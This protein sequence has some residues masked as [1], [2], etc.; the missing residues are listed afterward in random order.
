MP[1]AAAAMIFKDGAEAF[2]DNASA[3]GRWLKKHE[4]EKAFWGGMA[5]A[6]A[7]GVIGFLLGGP[8]GAGIGTGIGGIIGNMLGESIGKQNGFSHR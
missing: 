2:S 3:E 5:G 6:G 8:I 1:L 7:G 4:N